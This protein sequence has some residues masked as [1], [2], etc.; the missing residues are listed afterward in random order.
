MLVY[1][2]LRNYHWNVVGGEFYDVHEKFEVEYTQGAAHVD[3][4]AERMRMLGFK[5]ISTLSGFISKSSIKE[6]E[7]DLNAERMVKNIIVDYKTLLE[8]LHAT[9][10]LSLEHEDFGTDFM[11]RNMMAHIEQKIW[12]FQ[13][14]VK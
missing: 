6:S 14:F 7:E 8:N 11:A 13:S 2:K 9:V 12:M 4:I 3:E 10:K 5:P 1:Q